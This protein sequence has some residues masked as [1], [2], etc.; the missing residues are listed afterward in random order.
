MAEVSLADLLLMARAELC[1]AR[2]RVIASQELLRETS[3]EQMQRLPSSPSGRDVTFEPLR[4]R[5]DLSDA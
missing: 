5:M 2:D 4:A 1:E 3:A